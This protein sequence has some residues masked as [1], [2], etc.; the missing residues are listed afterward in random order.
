ML[1]KDN[2]IHL[3]LEVEMNRISSKTPSVL[4]SNTLGTVRF[5]VD[6]PG[7]ASEVL[8]KALEVLK[9]IVTKS[10]DGWPSDASWSEVLP[11]WFLRECAPEMSLEE[12]QKW[13]Q[14]WKSLDS[15]MQDKIEKEKKWSLLD[16][17][18]WLEP[19]HRKWFWWGSEE[20]SKNQLVIAVEVI[21]WPFAWGALAWL[22]RASG[23]E[24][25]EPEK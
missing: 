7:N 3:L 15:E 25:V 9:I 17:L 11:Q 14:W 23:A 24:R 4:N 5:L 2:K 18:Y 12:A 20:L 13:L 19:S 8:A 21:D 6:C 10:L 22:L 1:D 16:W